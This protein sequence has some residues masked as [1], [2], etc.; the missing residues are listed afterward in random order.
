LKGSY[1]DNKNLND[2]VS[3][4]LNELK[5]NNEDLNL[6]VEYYLNFINKLPKES[7]DGLLL[8]LKKRYLLLDIKSIILN[9]LDLMYLLNDIL[10]Y[11]TYMLIIYY[12]NSVSKDIT[13]FKTYNERIKYYLKSISFFVNNQRI[14]NLTLTQEEYLKLNIQFAENKIPELPPILLT[15]FLPQ[16][17]LLKGGNAKVKKMAKKTILGKERCI[18][19]KPGDRKEYLKHKGELITV[20]DYK[21]LMKDKK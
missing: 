16:K 15:E 1:L 19:K 8:K 12:H 2:K 6:D 10:Y 13:D 14:S 4:A 3:S 5:S 7:L 17:S 9:D 20:K 21:K 18:Y 11:T